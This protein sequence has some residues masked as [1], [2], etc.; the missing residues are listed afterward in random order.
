MKFHSSSYGTGVTNKWDPLNKVKVPVVCA[1]CANL[2]IKVPLPEPS[3][4]PLHSITELPVKVAIV[5]SVATAVDWEL[6]TNALSNPVQWIRASEKV[7]V[8]PSKSNL[9]PS[10]ATSSDTYKIILK[11][12][13]DA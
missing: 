7:A 1:F 4:L 9:A 6:K 5:K 2:G 11:V 8:P 10:A 12:Y 3:K 13:L